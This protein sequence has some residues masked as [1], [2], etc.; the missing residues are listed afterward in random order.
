MDVALAADRRGVAQL[1][2]DVLDH[3]HHMAL[4]V[5]LRLP[6]QLTQYRQRQDAASPGAVILGGEVGAG[7]GLQVGVDVGGADVM[8]LAVFIQILKQVLPGD[9]LAA[10]DDPRQAPVFHGDLMFNA[11]FAAEL[12]QDRTAIDLDVTAAQGGQAV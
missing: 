7:Q 5:R 11:A 2:G 12:E 1:P 3:L 6:L 4:G 10:L 8:P 9:F